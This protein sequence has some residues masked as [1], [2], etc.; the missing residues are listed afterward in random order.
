MQIT[1]TSQNIKW[2][3]DNYVQLVRMLIEAEEVPL[4]RL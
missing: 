2:K 3:N 4:D 1:H